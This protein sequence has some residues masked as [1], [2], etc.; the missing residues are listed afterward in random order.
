M[1]YI[2]DFF[3]IEQSRNFVGKYYAF[4]GQDCNNLKYIDEQEEK[5]FKKCQD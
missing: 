5:S 3:D 1:F 2:C 4:Q